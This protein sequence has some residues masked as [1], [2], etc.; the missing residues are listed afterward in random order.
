MVEKIFSRLNGRISG[1]HQGA[2]FLAVLTIGGQ[3]FSVVRDRVFAET[4]GSSITLDFY[5]A[6]FRIPD[7]Y[8][9]I[10]GGL[11]SSF[12]LLPFLVEARERGREA[13]KNLVANATGLFFIVSAVI[14]IPTIVFLE[15]ILSFLFPTFATHPQFGEFVL[16]G[17]LLLLQPVILG[18]SELFMTVVQL[19]RR[20]LVYAIAPILYTLGTIIG[21]T[22]FV[23]F[24]GISG[25]G[26]GVLL[27]AL[28]HALIQ[29]PTALS[30]G[31]LSK[32]H[33]PNT[34]FSLC[35]IKAST[36]R[37]L[38]L[39]L[40]GALFSV[41]VIIAARF[42]T[43]SVTLLGFASGLCAVPIV[44]IGRTYAVSAFT[45]LAESA[46]AK[47][48]DEFKNIVSNTAR[49]IFLW[50]ILATV[51]FIVLRA[52]IVRVVFGTDAFSWE[53]TRLTAALLA[54]LVVPIS[55]QSL[56]LLMGRAYY[57]QEKAWVPLFVQIAGFIVST[58]LALFFVSIHHAGSLWI[59]FLNDLLRVGDV[60]DTRVLSLVVGFSLGQL[61]T[62]IIALFVFHVTF[63][64]VFASCMRSFMQVFCASV[65]AGFS[66]YAT[67]YALGGWFSLSTFWAVFAQAGVAGIVGVG[68]FGLT[69]FAVKSR[70]LNEIRES[71]QKIGKTTKPVPLLEP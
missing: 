15:S 66:A 27:G 4:F 18:F 1:V 38:A 44:I 55:I 19:E 70:E 34:T 31:I 42:S 29:F 16:L 52:H 11:V 53:D 59:S 61:I 43:G 6:A 24:V 45:A 23:P 36:P 22:V 25:L 30:A 7:L 5:Y 9:A 51:L 56:I 10:I 35:L 58:S 12:V 64:K 40:Q 17:R 46:V 39:M 71:L 60:S 63:Q 41:L 69:L 3:I 8:Y 68:V 26:Y 14:V 20:F 57:A 28:L 33:I 37:I 54:V 67:L 49:H 47:K 32:P 50:T 48:M 2:Y 21:A 62:G 65:L 13:M